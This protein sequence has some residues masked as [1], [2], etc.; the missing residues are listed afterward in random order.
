MCPCEQIGVTA[1][2]LNER[3][4]ELSATGAL[5]RERLVSETVQ[6]VST[7]RSLPDNVRMIY[8]YW[9]EDFVNGTFSRMESGADGF[10]RSRN[11]ESRIVHQIERQETA[12]HTFFSVIKVRH[13][14]LYDI[15]LK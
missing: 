10:V 12:N 15:L 9:I 11:E 14:V 4:L 7:Q 5:N 6:R 8:L 3:L 13:D 1:T 2:K